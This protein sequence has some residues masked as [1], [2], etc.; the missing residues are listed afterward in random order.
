MMLPIITGLHHGT[1]PT[2]TFINSVAKHTRGVLRSV[3][4]LSPVIHPL[5]TP[6]LQFLPKESE[7]NIPTDMSGFLPRKP[8]LKLDF[9]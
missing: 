2:V 9:P 3:L 5:N 8:T 4:T 1:G 6:G 7:V